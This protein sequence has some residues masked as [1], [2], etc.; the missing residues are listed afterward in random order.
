MDCVENVEKE[1]DKS[2]QKF[3]NYSS[4][5]KDVISAEIST[6]EDLKNALPTGK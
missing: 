6:I 3:L 4:H 2:I 5:V 1:V